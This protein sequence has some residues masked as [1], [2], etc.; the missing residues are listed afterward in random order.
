MNQK[1][2]YFDLGVV[3]VLILDIVLWI[4]SGILSLFFND[5]ESISNVTSR[6]FFFMGFIQYIYIF[7]LM[8]WQF[9]EQ[10]INLVYGMFIGSL[11]ALLINIRF[12]IWIINLLKDGI[13]F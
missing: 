3:S 12:L 6:I 11:P 13:V 2:Y 1:K 8:V 7:P 10:N 4:V 9:R 5:N